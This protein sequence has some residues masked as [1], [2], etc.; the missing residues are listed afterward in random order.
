MIGSS[1]GYERSIDRSRL[2][3][4]A[5]EPVFELRYFYPKGQILHYESQTS[6]YRTADGGPRFT[7][8]SQEELRSRIR[9]RVLE[10]E[11]QDESAH[12]VAYH[13]PLEHTINGAPSTLAAQRIV[14]LRQTP[15][16][17][18][19]ETSEPGTVAGLLLPVEPVAVGARW[20]E[21]QRQGVDQ[22]L[23]PIEVVNHYQILKVEGNLVHIRYEAEEVSFHGDT[24]A[25]EGEA[26]AL[27]SHGHFD[28]DA[29][30]GVL[31]GFHVES[32]MAWKG[33]EY[34]FEVSSFH[35]MRLVEA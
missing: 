9:L 15:C 31:V 1:L 25:T 30:E 18:V 27:G 8:K 13:E 33:E 16:G 7:S 14:Y 34:L 28:F 26:Y 22:R 29:A 17:E 4:P 5:G 32:R 21:R 20:V 11:E 12:L 6:M 24:P 10:V 2:T 23:A 3:V 35:S 19:L